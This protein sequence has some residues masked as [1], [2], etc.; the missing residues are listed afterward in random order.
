MATEIRKLW[1]EV[2]SDSK[3][4]I[5]GSLGDERWDQNIDIKTYNE[6]R[7]AMSFWILQSY[8]WGLNIL[9]K[10]CVNKTYPNFWRDLDNL[11]KK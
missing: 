11:S 2:E 5:I 6:H 3:S 9:D 10:S 1:V 7:I 8:I 4:M